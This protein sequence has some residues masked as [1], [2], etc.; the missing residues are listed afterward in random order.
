MQDIIIAQDTGTEAVP[1]VAGFGRP[2]DAAQNGNI[3]AGVF[4]CSRQPA[5]MS[6]DKVQYYT[7]GSARQPEATAREWPIRKLAEMMPDGRG[8]D[9]NP[10]EP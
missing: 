9:Q 4:S 3:L 6:L 1:A 8:T 7:K 10:R 5:V 2:S